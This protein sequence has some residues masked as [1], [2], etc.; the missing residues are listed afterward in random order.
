MVM[1]RL[2]RIGKKNHP[3]YRVVV[4][5][6]QKDTKAP[7]LE[8]LG[9]YDPHTQPS[10]FEVDKERLLHWLSVG[11]QM[12][13]TVNNLCVTHKLINGKKRDNMHKV[14]KSEEEIKAE[15]EKATVPKAKPEEKAEVEKPVE[16]KKEKVKEEKKEQT[17]KE[18]AK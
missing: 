12:S 17:E 9:H 1:I 5:D 16:E 7:Y 2:A 13:T 4:S 11:A 15:A 3:T 10:T 8:A 14:E 6:K 18:E